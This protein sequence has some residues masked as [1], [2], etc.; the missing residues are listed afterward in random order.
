MQNATGN[1]LRPIDEA[2]TTEFIIMCTQE[3]EC[4]KD[5]LKNPL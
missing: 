4:L 3:I 1:C 5:D 2:Y